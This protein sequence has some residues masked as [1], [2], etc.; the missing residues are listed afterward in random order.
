[1]NFLLL[2]HTS[3][4]TPIVPTIGMP[5]TLIDRLFNHS[6]ECVRDFPAWRVRFPY[7]ALTTTQHLGKMFVPRTLANGPT[8]PLFWI[9]R[10]DD[11]DGLAKVLAMRDLRVITD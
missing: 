10:L 5:R 2:R 11:L 4:P 3:P 6:T 1:M 7:A 9:G 8:Y